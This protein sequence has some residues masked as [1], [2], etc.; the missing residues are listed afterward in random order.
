MDSL[1]VGGDVSEEMRKPNSGGEEKGK[2]RQNATGNG[3]GRAGTQQGE[4]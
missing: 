4:K 3:F 1:A 2:A